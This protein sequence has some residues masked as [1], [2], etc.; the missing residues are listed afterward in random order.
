MMQI[1]WGDSS[2]HVREQSEWV[3]AAA[4]HVCD[5]RATRT[6]AAEHT[7]VVLDTALQA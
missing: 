7:V 6:A 3:G 2:T 1:P 4:K 5:H